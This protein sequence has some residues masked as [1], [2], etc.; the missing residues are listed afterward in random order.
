MDRCFQSHAVTTL[1]YLCVCELSTGASVVGRGALS[2]LALESAPHF[3]GLV[4]PKGWSL[5]RPRLSEMLEP[6]LSLEAAQ[7]VH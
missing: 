3:R 7:L 4:H 2:L 6:E 5:E 1:G